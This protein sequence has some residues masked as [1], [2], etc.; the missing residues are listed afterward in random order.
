MPADRV[1][2]RSASD[3]VRF[4]EWL[5]L[6]QVLQERAPDALLSVE[7]PDRYRSIVG[8]FVDDVRRMLRDDEPFERL[9]LVV[10]VLMRMQVLPE[11]FG[12]AASLRRR[13][14]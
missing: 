11:H 4:D 14:G 10:S 1:D 2:P 13:C 3:V 8:R 12:R 9:D 7:F 6:V 5:A